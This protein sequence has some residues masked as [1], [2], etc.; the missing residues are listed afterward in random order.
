[1]ASGSEQVRWHRAEQCTCLLA[2]CK[3]AKQ[4]P[5][6]SQT[7]IPHREQQSSCL[8]PKTN[9]MSIPQK[10]GAVP[11][12]EMAKEHGIGHRVKKQGEPKRYTKPATTNQ[13]AAMVE[14]PP[15]KEFL[16]DCGWIPFNFKD[17]GRKS[18]K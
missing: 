11:K 3:R 5:T 13:P 10:Y 14:I 7:K 8:L 4:R 12:Q 2:A 16:K 9:L 18:V 17:Q 1:M 6:M 15:T